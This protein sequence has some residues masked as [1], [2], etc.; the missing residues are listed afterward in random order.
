MTRER[1]LLLSRKGTTEL[2]HAANVRRLLIITLAMLLTLSACGFEE[3]AATLIPQIG[4]EPG[5]AI[6]FVANGN[7][8]RWDGEIERITDDGG[9]RSPRW[10]PGGDRFAYSRTNENLGY[11]ELVIASRDGAPLEQLTDNRPNDQPGSGAFVRNAYW[12]MDPVWSPAGD[13]LAFVSDKEG[14][15]A[16]PWEERLFDPMYIWYVESPEIPPYILRGSER[17]GLTQE[18][19]TFSPDG[20]HL[21][22]VVRTNLPT[23]ERRPEIWT[24]DLKTG[25]TTPVVS[26]TDPAYAPAWSPDG[27]HLAYVQRNGTNNDI[28]IAPLDG[29]P[30]Y[31]LT[32][33]GAHT[34]PTWAPDGRGLA[35]FSALSDGEIEAS[36]VSLDLGED[37]RLTASDPQR[38]FTTNGIDMTSGMSWLAID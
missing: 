27:E 37:G 29:S 31:P 19:P 14:W 15:E 22:F 12:A 23:G 2:R 5:G 8:M 1:Q 17:I 20:Q 25:A 32:T 38:L 21:A 34:A 7:V 6:L 26:D 13:Q 9:A 24:L 4:A 11:S 3:R 28:W 36:Y 10:S 16:A 18:W 30:A 33:D 35:F